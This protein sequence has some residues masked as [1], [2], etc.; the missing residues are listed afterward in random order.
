MADKLRNEVK[1]ILDGKDYTMRATFACIRA[2]ESDLRKSI[3][4]VTANAERLSVTECV[5]VIFH[6]IRGA[7]NDQIQLEDIGEAVI[8]EGYAKSFP[9]VAEFL[10]QVMSGVSLGKSEKDKA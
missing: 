5:T 3:I 10:V 2:I 6:G 8:Q 7:G 4:E 9:A 1:I